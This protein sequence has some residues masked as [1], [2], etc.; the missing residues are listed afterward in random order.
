MSP[1]SFNVEVKA[2]QAEKVHN[3]LACR[4]QFT[5]ALGDSPIFCP[6]KFKPYSAVLIFTVAL[7]SLEDGG[8]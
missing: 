3:L 6:V 8:G 5:K 7:P 4:E 1:I 2:V